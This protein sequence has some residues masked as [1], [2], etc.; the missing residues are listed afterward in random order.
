MSQ[1]P[2]RDPIVDL[3]AASGQPEY[4]LLLTRAED[5]IRG[6]ARGTGEL[7]DVVLRQ[8]NHNRR[9]ASVQPDK[10]KEAKPDATLNGYVQR[11]N[12]CGR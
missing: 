6:R 8:G 2:K 3:Y 4:T 12:Q 9:V 11:L 7:G 10:V 1:T 5:T